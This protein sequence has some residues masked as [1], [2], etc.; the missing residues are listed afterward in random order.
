MSP[1]GQ[2]E[3]E[4]RNER[5]ISVGVD[6]H[7]KRC[8]ACLKDEKGR[9]V[10]EL[11][12]P[13]DT[14]GVEQLGRLL[15]SYGDARI[16]LESTGNLWTRVYD[17]LS[18]QGFKVVLA[19]PYKTRIIA[20][21]KVKNDRMDARVLADLVRADLIAE[22]YIPSREVR[23][24]RALLRHRRSLVEDTVAVKNRIHNQL[25]KYDLKPEY[26]DIFGKQGREW[27]RSIQLTPV[28]RTILDVDLRQLQSLEE[29]INDLTVKIAQEAITRPDVKLLMG[30]TGID[31]YSAML[32][33]SEMGPVTR[34]PTAKKLVSY[35]GLAPGTR[36]S[37]EHTFHG[38]ITKQGNKYIRWVLVEAAQNASR[39]DPKLRGLYQ[40]VATRR[41]H[42][43]AITAVARKMLV[44]IYYVLKRHE[45]YQGQRDDLLEK[46]IKRLQRTV[47]SSLQAE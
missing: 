31:Y 34:F 9:L 15:A 16:A 13:N 28:D 47:D 44:S 4:R 11:S 42:Q 26:S 12:I 43:K 21:A 14:E 23:E 2:Q 41:G 20:E 1:E 10:Q 30:F 5:T 6:V 37:A 32:V 29:S 45:E 33:L 27:L 8:Q 46:K 24:Q 18:Q 7:K 19:N 17:G 40:R 36:Q 25:D 38:R 3:Q 35:A 39:Y 22:S